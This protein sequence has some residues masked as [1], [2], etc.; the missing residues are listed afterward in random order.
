M[1]SLNKMAL[2]VLVVGT[3][4]LGLPHVTMAEPTDEVCTIL[5]D[6]RLADPLGKIAAEFQFRTGTTVTLETRKAKE[7]EAAVQTKQAAA[8]V[9]LI[10][11]ERPGRAEDYVSPAVEKLSGAKAVAWKYP[12]GQPV[13]AAVVGDHPAAKKLL[14]FIGGPTGHL[15]WSQSPDGFT[16]TTGRTHAEAFKW[17]VDN[18]VGHTYTMT[19]SRMIRECGGMKTGLCIDIGCGTGNLAVELAGQTELTIVGLDID[20]DMKPL[21]D[22]H[23]AEKGFSDRIRFVEGDAQDLPFDDDS[24]D[25]IIS[26]GTL[27]F[28]PDI[29]KCLREVDRVLKPTGVAFLGGRYL[30]T[31]QPD[32]ISDE[33]LAKI[34]AECGVKSAKLITDRG[35][36]VKI[37]GAEAPQ[38]ANQVAVGPH[39]LSHRFIADTRITTGEALVLCRS[40]GGLEQGL[41]QGFLE[42]TSMKLTALYPNEEV[43]AEARKRIAAA[44]L[45]GRVKCIVG[46]VYGIPATPETYDA[47]LGVGPILLWGE[48][49]K[50]MKEIHRV[51]KQ[52]GAALV[53][54]RFLGMPDWRK[55]PSAVLRAS[56]KATGL[57]GITISDDM[58]QWVV[59][60]KGVGEGGR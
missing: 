38:A 43:A 51:L 57:P 42:N 12:T 37:V 6:V 4:L 54:G 11:A 20:A 24:A 40:D 59:I 14:E 25:Y 18:R 22:K 50:G 45:T 34:V 19:A 28:I 47:V 55:T 46:N 16:M 41:Q 10:M 49:E 56:A 30:Y 5:A 60:R 44:G 3:F 31:P 1:I 52:G 36:W 9:V 2:C 13:W 7:V 53:G 48:R 39:L 26:R 35:Q 23:V 29:G 8:D 27:T 33:K 58:G 21:F 17:V 15:R 32:K